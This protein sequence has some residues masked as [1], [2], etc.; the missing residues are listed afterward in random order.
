MERISRRRFLRSA[1]VALELASGSGAYDVMQMIFIRSGR[2]IG[3]GWA[4]P[5]NPFI[6][7]ARLTDKAV[8][9]VGDFVAGAMA[10]FKRGETIYALPWLSDSTV[11]GYRTD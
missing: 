11:V 1:S 7:D 2:W 3:A 10:P 8:L 6:D 5:L 4:E 9:D